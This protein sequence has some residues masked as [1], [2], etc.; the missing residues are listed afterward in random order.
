MTILGIKDPAITVDSLVVITGCSGFIG[1]H[2][3]NQVLAAGY[4]VRG[5]T[6]DAKKNAW[7]KDYFVDK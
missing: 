3:T 6:R 4:K 5:V 2:V 7:V 1:S